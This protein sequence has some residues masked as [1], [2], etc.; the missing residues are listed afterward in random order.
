[1]IFWDDGSTVCLIREAFAEK[2]KIQGR[3]ICLW[4]QAAGHKP[5]KW[6]TSVFTVKLI[7]RKGEE[8]E[9]KAFSVDSITSDIERV[10][11]NGITHVFPKIEASK[12]KRPFGAVDILVGINFAS[13]HP[14][15][16]DRSYVNGDLRLLK[17]MFGSGWVLDGRHSELKVGNGSMVMNSLVHRICHSRVVQMDELPEREVLTEK[18]NMIKGQNFFAMNELKVQ[19]RL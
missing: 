3:R 4:V 2:L 19:Q 14:T 11:I 5:E 15:V 8:H 12:M 6:Y 9:I 17:S 1:M 10:D 18:T 13:L 7:D 16:P